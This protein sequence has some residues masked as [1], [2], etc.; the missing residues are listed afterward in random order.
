MKNFGAE[1]TCP[2]VLR[3]RGAH[4]EMLVFR[5]PRAGNQFIKG[6]I[7][8]GETPN[9]AAVRELR[10]ESG[11]LLTGMTPLGRREVGP[12]SQVWHFFVTVLDGLPE[13]WS[14]DTEDDNGHR[15]DF[16]WHTLEQPL[17]EGWHP[18]FHEAFA[19]IKERLDA[20]CL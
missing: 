6:T 1:K 17:D 20:A 12:T 16:F 14:H 19:F 5:H 10:E 13:S 7:E 8:V 15:F 9:D 3:K 18:M 4:S 11:L 2:V